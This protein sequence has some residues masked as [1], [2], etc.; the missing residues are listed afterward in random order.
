MKSDASSKAS[1]LTATRMATVRRTAT[2]YADVIEA[3]IGAIPNG[4]TIGSK[5][6][7]TS[8]MLRTKG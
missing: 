7:Y 8:R 6:A 3:K 4:F 1:P 5:A 2:S